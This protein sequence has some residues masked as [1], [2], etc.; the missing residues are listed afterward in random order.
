MGL[1]ESIGN[2]LNSALDTVCNFAGR[3]SEMIGPPEFVSSALEFVSKIG[4]AIPGM[5]VIET[6]VLAAGIIS[7][8]A[9][10]LGIKV[11]E[12][13]DE[14]AMKA[15]KDSSMPK[16]F[17]STEAY[18]NHLH[19]DVHLS[20]DDLKRLDNM[21]IEEKTA[22]TAVGGYL[23]AKACFEKLGF[24]TGDLKNAFLEGRIGEAIGD[25]CSLKDIFS[26]DEF[27]A[28]CRSL[29]EKGLSSGAL[30]DY[31]HNRTDDISIDRIVQ[32][33]ICDA[34]RTSDPSLTDEQVMEKIYRMN[35]ED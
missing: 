26:P 34:F 28:C 16:E 9:E 33:V 25:L 31:L 23:Y 3:L 14:L 10:I 11:K 22:Y 2:T 19:E 6:I 1:F 17:R 4:I 20:E 24:F 12:P 27:V 15:E 7:K 18:I 8:V 5:E 13:L 21:D 35:I 32:S 30:F 29:Q